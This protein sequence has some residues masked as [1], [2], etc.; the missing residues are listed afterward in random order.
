[1]IKPNP[2]SAHP[3]IIEVRIPIFASS[4]PPTSEKIP[5]IRNVIIEAFARKDWECSDWTTPFSTNSLTIG[6]ENT[7]IPPIA[8]PLLIISPD[9]AI[10]KISH[11]KVPKGLS[12]FIWIFENDKFAGL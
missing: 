8:S 9:V 7:G 4:H 11:L 5:D 1:M 10:A 12:L 6:V 2:N 3:R